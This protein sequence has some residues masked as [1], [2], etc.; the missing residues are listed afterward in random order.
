K[1]SVVDRLKTAIAELVTDAGMMPNAKEIV[2]L[3]LGIPRLLNGEPHG[4]EIQ[5]FVVESSIC[6]LGEKL[7]VIYESLIDKKYYVDQSISGEPKQD[8]GDW[9][10]ISIMPVNIS[11]YPNEGAVREYSGL[12]ADEV[13]PKGLIAG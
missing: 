6:E 1:C 10:T 2:L 7:A 3:I 8:A 4:T 13:G 9:K 12:K 11:P 5:G